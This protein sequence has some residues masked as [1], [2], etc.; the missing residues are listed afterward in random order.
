MTTIQQLHP[1][2]IAR[3]AADTIATT[4]ASLRSFPEVVVYDNGSTDE[5]A[6]I[7]ARFANVRVE[8][9]RFYGFGPTKN[10]AA[11][12]AAGPWI[13][14]I[15][16][17]ERIDTELL[18]QL[19]RLDLSETRR[20][21]AVDRRNLLLGKHV[22]RAGW[23]NNWLVRVYHRGTC[24]F[25]DVRVHE[26][27]VVPRGVSLIR[28]EGALWHDAVSDIDQFLHK[29]SLYSELN[30]GA[31]PKIRSIP[32][33]LLGA[34]CAFVR[35]YFLRLGFLEGWRGLLIAHCDAEG[36]FFKHFKR[37]VDA[38][39]HATPAPTS[40]RWITRAKSLVRTSR[41]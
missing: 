15:D 2:V 40:P 30:R 6:A 26:K 29:V 1:V 17:D 37:Y 12:L 35:S 19:G 18:E 13:L 7:C 10:H 39:T 34:A 3:D 22:R 24:R 5:T 8:R 36:T 31:C 11:S 21:Y 20:A 38:Q 41:D 27:V 16:A 28:L 23:G 9:G 33:I 14:S 32:H 25:S 4:L